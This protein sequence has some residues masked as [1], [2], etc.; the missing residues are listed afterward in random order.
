ME[1][2]FRISNCLA[3]SQSDTIPIRFGVYRRV[4]LVEIKKTER[5][6][7]HSWPGF[8]QKLSARILA[9]Y[10]LGTRVLFLVANGSGEIISLH[11]ELVN[12]VSVEILSSLVF[13][14]V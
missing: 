9:C 10:A 2:M 1:S 11:L 13:G 4:G 14:C 5:S 3:L 6:E 12:I 7:R 8:D